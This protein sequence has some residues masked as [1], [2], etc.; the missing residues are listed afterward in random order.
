MQNIRWRL[1]LA[2]SFIFLSQDNALSAGNN[3]RDIEHFRRENTLLKTELRIA[4][5][6]LTYL[7]LDINDKKI[8]LKAKGI[9]LREFNIIDMKIFG[10]RYIGQSYIFT[11]RKALFSPKRTEITPQQPKN[12]TADNSSS[13]PAQADTFD[14]EDMPTNYILYFNNDLSISVTP[15]FYKNI[16]LSALNYI[17]KKLI[18]LWNSLQLI[19]N[20]LKKTPF[21]RIE[22]VMDTDDARALYWSLPE[23]ADLIII[24]S[25]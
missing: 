5:K 13:V 7:V 10:K 8:F 11:E 12:E 6:P 24:K 21:T 22:T 15:Q 1:L 3:F 25:H 17:K 14:I 23:N 18:H 9:I 19:W 20:Y 2:V 4:D 16:F